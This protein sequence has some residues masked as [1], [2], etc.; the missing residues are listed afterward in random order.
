MIQ[1]RFSQEVQ[2]AR[3]AGLPLV[4]LESTII[5]HGMPYPQN[6]E[7]AIQVEDTVRQNGAVPATIAVVHGE[8]CVGLDAMLLEEFAQASGIMKCSRRDL[9]YA[10]SA[11]KHGAT[12]VAATMMVAA[13]AGIRVFATGG[14]GGVHRG[15]E[16]SFDISADLPEFALTNVA[17]VSAGAKAILDLPKTLEYLETMGVPVVG[18]RTDEF[19]AFYYPSSGLPL[20]MRMDDV[21]DI[22]R[23]M[24]AREAMQVR[25]GVVVANPIPSADALD[26]VFIEQAIAN[27]VN[28]AEAQSVRGKDV[29]PFLL[30]HLHTVTSGKSQ[31]ANKSLVLNNAAVAA[32]L[33]VAYQKL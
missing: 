4:A 1:L 16:E 6:L 23:F 17:V 24:K 7:V 29:T 27:A 12:T 18:Y 28:E 9:A 5:S 15:A 33:S 3:K 25:G 13:M 26:K 31:H 30:R 8:V 14:I 21:D 11:G 19:P 32:Q 22:A 2:E 20:H 10:V